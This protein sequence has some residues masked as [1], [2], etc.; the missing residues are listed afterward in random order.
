V[1]PSRRLAPY[2]L[3]GTLTLGAGLGAGLGL[4]QGPMTHDATISAVTV[5]VTTKAARCTVST[6]SDGSVLCTGGGSETPTAAGG[7]A[8]IACLTRIGRAVAKAN[9]T[10]AVAIEK[11]VRSVM[12]TCHALDEPSG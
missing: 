12:S 4:S 1:K 9:P 2:L 11:A 10:N 5:I 7:K 6:G 3:L 8:L